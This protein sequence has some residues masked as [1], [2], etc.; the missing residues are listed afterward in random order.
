[1]Q[2][3]QE[4]ILQQTVFYNLKGHLNDNN[5]LI[6]K[7]NIFSIPEDKKYLILDLSLLQS[8]SGD[9]IR[10]FYESIRYFQKR[11]GLVIFINPKQEIELL[12]QFLKLDEEVFIVN[13]YE[14]AKEVILNHPEID[15]ITK[16]IEIQ[17]KNIDDVFVRNSDILVTKENQVK[18][19][20]NHIE[21]VDNQLLQE[22]FKSLNLKMNQLYD[23]ILNQ[24]EKKEDR[25]FKELEKII[26]LIDKK[27][28]VVG[29]SIE[30]KI[31]TLQNEQNQKWKDLKEFAENNFFQVS[32]KVEKLEKNQENFDIELKSIKNLIKDLSDSSKIQS[33]EIKAVLANRNG[34]PE[35][36][37]FQFDG[38]F[39]IE[40]K[41]CTA[42][43]RVQRSGKYLCQKCNT[44]FNVLPDGTVDF[45][46][47]L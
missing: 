45:S 8:L 40:C 19:D 22:S 12:I 3:I 24:T 21:K 17:K 47:S 36:K 18:E 23:V 43:L 30:N 37:G 20:K 10:V 29:L 44:K 42:V 15:V 35:K 31:H 38:Y 4:K 28:D 14:K 46:G 5:A 1:M 32:E 2:N 26:K 16:N 7:K 34:I 6:F 27:T 33:E 9:G 13:D 41:S 11:K 39:L 25:T